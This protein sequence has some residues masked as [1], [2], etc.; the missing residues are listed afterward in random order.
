[1]K[2]GLFN[3]SFPPFIDG[4]ANAMINY[5]GP[6]GYNVLSADEIA[7]YEQIIADNQ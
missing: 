1:M 2:I 3:D 4:V 7:E 5:F 6:D